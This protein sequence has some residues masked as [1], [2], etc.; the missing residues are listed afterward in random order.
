ME[1]TFL[2]IKPDGVQ[3][4]LVGEIIQRFEA[5]GFTLVGLKMMQ[6]SSELAEKHYAVH[7]ERPFFPSLV[8]FITSSPVVAMVW[9][10]EGVIASARKIIGATNPLNAEPGTIRGDF[11]ISVG[12]NLIHGSDGPDTAKDEVSLWFSDAELADWTPAITPWVVE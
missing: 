7:K 6:V 9:Q 12:R 10:G 3:R 4:N 5:K 11:G 1:R 8:D 2:M